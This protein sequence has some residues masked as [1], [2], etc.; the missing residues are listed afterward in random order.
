MRYGTSNKVIN[1]LIIVQFYIIRFPDFISLRSLSSLLAILQSHWPS[2]CPCNMW[3]MFPPQCLCTCSFL[4]LEQSV[5]GP[6]DS[7]RFPALQILTQT[8]YSK[9]LCHITLLPFLHSVHY[10]LK[11]S[12][13][14]ISLFII[15]WR[16][17][18][19]LFT[20]ISTVPGTLRQGGACIS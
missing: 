2:L 15:I 10:S 6:L 17:R 18:P 12:Y 16:Q 4:C 11:F 1:K 20:I 13:S 9:L 3:S 14:F 7:W 5:S 19:T 8:T